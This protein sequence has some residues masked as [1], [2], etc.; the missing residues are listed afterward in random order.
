M[1][2]G[3]Q[4]LKRRKRAQK[5][6][7]GCHSKGPRPLRAPLHVQVPPLR[8]R[9]ADIIDLQRYFLR[10]IGQRTG[11]RIALSREAERQLEGYSFPGNTRVREC[12]LTCDAMRGAQAPACTMTRTP[13]SMSQHCH[14]SLPSHAPSICELYGLAARKGLPPEHFRCRCC[15]RPGC[16]RTCYILH[17]TCQLSLPIVNHHQLCF[18]HHCLMLYATATPHSAGA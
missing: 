16:S 7:F 1:A 4:G 11:K 6:I 3:A 10:K 9:P 15:R 8:V 2:L 17:P 14:A 18:D 5:C 13:A 12:R